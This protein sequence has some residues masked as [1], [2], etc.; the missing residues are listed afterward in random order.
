LTPIENVLRKWVVL[1]S[2]KEYLMIE[3][4]DSFLNA[5][6]T[7][8]QITGKNVNEIAGELLS[9]TEPILRKAIED[10]ITSFNRLRE[11]LHRTFLDSLNIRA[12]EE[13]I[14]ESIGGNK[15]FM[16]EE[17]DVNLDENTLFL[18]FR[19]LESSP[20]GIGDLWIKFSLVPRKL[21]FTFFMT[22]YVRSKP[23]I[24]PPCKLEY[25]VRTK[26]H[27]NKLLVTVEFNVNNLKDKSIINE[28]LSVIGML[29]KNLES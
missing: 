29:R 12:L 10:R 17:V 5:L 4:E 18:M 2:D 11:E 24:K 22:K 14:L 8:A 3:V 1:S 25:S 9:L 21:G 23:T 26:E 13:D 20:F 15:F 16:L 7:L 19:E 6:K 27:L 28:A